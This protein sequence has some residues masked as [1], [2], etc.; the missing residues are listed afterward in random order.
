MRA[1]GVGTITLAA[2]AAMLSATAP[3]DEEGGHLE[4]TPY[5]W[6]V[7][8]DGSV[9]VGDKRA[10]F[11]ANFSDLADKVD[12]AG[13]LMLAGSYGRWVS[14][15]EA[16]CFSLDRDFSAGTGGHL[17]SDWLLVSAAAGYRFKGF[18]TGGTVD[19]LGGV[20]YLRNH[21]EITAHGGGAADN[22]ADLVDAI[23]ML[24]PSMP[25]KFL[26]E[27]LRLSSTLSIGVGESDVVWELQ[28]EL[29]YQFTERFAGRAGYRRVQYKFSAGPAD[30]DAGL[31]G[32][33]VGCGVTW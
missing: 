22:T 33:L 31:Q 24:R 21:N 11:S 19:V 26:T 15:V 1:C 10:D 5:V 3:A 17:D 14:F 16:D 9:G 4:I 23:V 2:C 27:K 28:P 18:M 20:R 13:E 12:L 6:L 25:L 29:Q 32:F 8:L 30:V 7:N